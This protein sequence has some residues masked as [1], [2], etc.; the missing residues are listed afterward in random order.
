MVNI[1]KLAWLGLM[2]ALLLC[3]F[4]GALA[5]EEITLDTGVKI[6]L[7]DSF[8][9]DREQK[10]IR[11]YKDTKHQ[12]SFGYKVMNGQTSLSAV[13]EQLQKSGYTDVRTETVQGVQMCYGSKTGS[14]GLRT[15]MYYFNT[16]NGHYVMLALTYNPKTVGAEST[17][18]SVLSSLRVQSSATPTPD[19]GGTPS[20][21]VI[22]TTDVAAPAFS[23]TGTGG[24]TISS[25]AYAGKNLILI[26]GT[27]SGAYTYTRV[28]LE[29][30]YPPLAELRE[31]GVQVLVGLYGDD[32]VSEPTEAQ[33]SRFADAYPGITFGRIKPAV[34]LTDDTGGMW[35]ALANVGNSMNYVSLPVVF[36][37]SANARLLYY[38]VGTCDNAHSVI[39]KALEMADKYKSGTGTEP[40]PA[41]KADDR[42]ITVGNGVYT[43]S[44][45]NAV[46]SGPAS[47]D[48]TSLEMPTRFT[49]DGKEYK[50]T[51]I[52]DNACKGLS[53]L[54]SVTISGNVKS[55]GKNAFRDCSQLKTITIITTRLKE[56]KI[57]ANA[58][59]NIA[60]KP[61]VKCPASVRQN[62]RKWLIKKGLPKK[63]AFK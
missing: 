6:T 31:H 47:P 8:S 55:I 25:S 24:K 58:F 41:P 38:S 62:Y 21:A 61:V 28:F 59:K 56:S 3:C 45:K 10:E 60:K 63:A 40:T 37:R 49:A 1:R 18:E 57:G 46:L 53:S 23:W 35:Q 13:S 2:T 11:Y 27:A 48:I 51:G 15:A 19:P 42:T 36:L 32:G 43:L 12:V 22:R 54:A 14:T 17:V 44:G 20:G 4:S 26:Y 33:L 5:A 9:F 52:A 29:T 30:L 16:E 39:G 50:V 7:P 34:Y